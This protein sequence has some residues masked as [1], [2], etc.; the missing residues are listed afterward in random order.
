[1]D[2]KYIVLVFLSVFLFLASCGNEE[3][4]PVNETD[5][6]ESLCTMEYIPICGKDG[7]TYQ[8]SCFSSIRNVGVDYI[9]PCQYT[10]CSFNGQA[11]Y[12]MDNM[13]Y[14]EDDRGRPYIEVLYG[15]FSI[16]ADGDGW[17]YTKAINAESSFYNNRMAEY[18]AG[19]T[20]S[21]NAI[22]CETTEEIPEQLKEFLKTHGQIIQ[23]QIASYTESN[24]TE[25]SSVAE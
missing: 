7:L 16:Q 2:K 14:Y 23:L 18:E 17:V 25:N 5:T 9:G 10:V 19:V 4:Q 6:E 3:Q 20:E 11:Y 8:N 24:T 21:G 22:T 15:T 1:M 13:F 12:M